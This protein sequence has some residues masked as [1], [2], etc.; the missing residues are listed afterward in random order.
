[1]ILSENFGF[2]LPN[3]LICCSNLA[4]RVLDCMTFMVFLF[5]E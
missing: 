4:F 2:F 3:F 1:M 5:F